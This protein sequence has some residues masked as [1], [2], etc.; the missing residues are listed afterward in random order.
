MQR[1]LQYDTLE[2]LELTHFDSWAAQF[3]ETVTSMELKPEG[4][5]FQQKTRFANFYNLPQLMAIFKEVADI[6]TADM[7]NLPVPKANYETVVCKPSE[8][9]KEMVSS[10]AE[11]ADAVRC[12]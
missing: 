3:G 6:Q 12:V 1:Y 10:L 7:L 9:Q 5:G 2:R 4:K 11:R 8:M